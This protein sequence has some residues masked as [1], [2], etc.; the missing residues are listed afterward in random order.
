[1]LLLELMERHVHHANR[2]FHYL[3]TRGY[4]GLGLLT[5]EHGLGNLGA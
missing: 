1:M 4:Y 5:A 2:A 3:L